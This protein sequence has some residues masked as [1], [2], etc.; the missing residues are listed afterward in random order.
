MPREYESNY[1]PLFSDEDV[2]RV[3]GAVRA[4]EEAARKNL[5]AIRS[6]QD[7]VASTMSW[8][9]VGEKLLA[10]AGPLIQRELAKPDKPKEEKDKL[11]GLDAKIGEFTAFASS[12]RGLF[13]GGF[14]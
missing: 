2:Q 11:K 3:S 12:L 1:D 6:A 13:P 9:G 10:V 7:A 14:A 8:L 5:E 4:F